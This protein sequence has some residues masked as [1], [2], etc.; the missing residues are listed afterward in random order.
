MAG[1]RRLFQYTNDAGVLYQVELDESNSTAT[2]GGKIMFSDRSAQLPRL[3][4]KTKLRFVNAYVK[5]N[6]DI[7]RKFYVGNPDAVLQAVNGATLSANVYPTAED[8]VPAK[9]DWVITSYR[10]EQSSPP[11]PVSTPDTGL[12]DGTLNSG[13][14]A[15]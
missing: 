6:P 4:G 11:L 1:S 15:P 10:G 14:S 7:K 8:G 3:P 5:S 9:S 12:T 2:V 13:G